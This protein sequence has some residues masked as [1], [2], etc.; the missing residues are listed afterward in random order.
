MK[1]VSLDKVMHQAS[2]SRSGKGNNKRYAFNDFSNLIDLR[3]DMRK[4]EPKRKK[5]KPNKIVKI[6]PAGSMYINKTHVFL[7]EVG[8][9]IIDRY[10]T[11]NKVRKMYP[12]VLEMMHSIDDEVYGDHIVFNNA[13]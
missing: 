9:V 1:K 11:P 6:T 7:A 2:T 10:V 13:H 12:N 3:D 5:C 4:S 8:W